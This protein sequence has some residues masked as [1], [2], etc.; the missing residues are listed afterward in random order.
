D[1]LIAE[2]GELEAASALDRLVRL[3]QAA[4]DRY[5]VCMLG[6]DIA[7]GGGKLILSAGAPRAVGDDEERMLLAVRQIV[8]AEQPLPVRAGLNRGRVFAGDIG[9]H[10]RR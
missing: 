7:P 2:R 8:T 4:V 6:T 5:E 10:Y 1:E 9:P 3:A